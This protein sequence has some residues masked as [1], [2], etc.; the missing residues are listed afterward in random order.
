MKIL[1]RV[2]PRAMQSTITEVSGYNCPQSLQPYFRSIPSSISRAVTI[3]TSLTANAYHV[4]VHAESL[5][6]L[7]VDSD[8][9]E[10]IHAQILEL[11]GKQLSE[12]QTRITS[13]ESARLIALFARSCES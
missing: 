12:L 10:E 6:H 1:L 3:H 7:D 2:I 11:C 5:K 9:D 8:D 4:G 13:F